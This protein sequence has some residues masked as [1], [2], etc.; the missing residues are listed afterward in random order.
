MNVPVTGVPS[1][2]RPLMEMVSPSAKELSWVMSA[3]SLVVSGQWNQLVFS[4]RQD[5]SWMITNQGVITDASN[6]IIYNLFQQDMI[7]LRVVMRLAWQLPNPINKVE[8]TEANRVPFAA[9][10]SEAAE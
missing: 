7:A 9:L 3:N 8:A 4:M 5:I 1:R 2:R 6:N 10:T